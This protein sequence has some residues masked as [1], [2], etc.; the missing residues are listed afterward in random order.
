MISL[1]WIQIVLYLLILYMLVKPLGSYLASVYQGKQTL[2]TPM[3]KP[4][5]NLIYRLMGVRSEDE[6][7]WKTY[8]I[9]GIVFSFLSMVVVYLIQRTQGILPLNPQRLGAVASDL[10]F[11]TS[12]SFITN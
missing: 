1:S 7:D 9:A 4:A 2:L 11:N 6:M 5:E 3:I 12:A 8:A 10:A